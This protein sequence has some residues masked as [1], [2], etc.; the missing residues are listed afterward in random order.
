VYSLRKQ[1]WEMGDLIRA[2]PCYPHL[3]LTLKI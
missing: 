1:T 3:G 2:T